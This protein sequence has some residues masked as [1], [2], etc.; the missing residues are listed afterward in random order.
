MASQMG[1][2]T[3]SLSPATQ[4]DPS[5]SYTNRAAVLESISTTPSPES[6]EWKSLQ[7]IVATLRE[8]IDELESEN[9]DLVGKLGMA[10]SSQEALR[11]QVAALKQETDN[12]QDGFRM[13]TLQCAEGNNRYDRL[14]AESTAEKMDLQAQI[15]DL[16]VSTRNRS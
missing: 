4:G 9:R 11:T 13:L 16:E 6:E 7:A 1:P 5:T 8:K 10:A 14:V 15:L 3:N 12:Q 2:I